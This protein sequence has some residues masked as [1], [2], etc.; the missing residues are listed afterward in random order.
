MAVLLL[1]LKAQRDGLFGLQLKVKLHLRL[2]V[3]LLGGL[4]GCGGCG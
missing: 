4:T 2:L 3:L 1:L